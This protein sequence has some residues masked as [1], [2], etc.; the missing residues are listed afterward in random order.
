MYDDAGAG[1]AAGIGAG[2]LILWLV[3]AIFFL[4]VY[5]KIFTKAGKPGW[6]CIIPIYNIILTLEIVKRPGWWI[7]LVLIVPLANIVCLIIIIFDLAKSFGKGVGF[8]FGLLF[9][10]II[11]LPILAFG[12]SEYTPIKREIVVQT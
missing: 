1:A 5:W 8:G 7:I 10:P 9:L 2:M 6:G 3:V 11:F 12:S 4:I